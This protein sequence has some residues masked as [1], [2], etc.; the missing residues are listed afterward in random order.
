MLFRSVSQ[1]RYLVNGIVDNSERLEGKVAAEFVNVE[2]AQDI[3]GT[4]TFTNDV[5]I[6]GNLTIHGTETVVNSETVTTKDN[7]IVINYGEV[8]AGVTA[9]KA[10]IKVDRGTEPDYEFVFIEADDS[11]KIGKEGELQK[12]A[13]REDIPIDTGLAAWD[14]STS[15]FVTSR[16]VDVDSVS[17]GNGVLTW[18]TDQLL[19]NS[20][21]GCYVA[22]KLYRDWET[23]RKSV[24]RER[25]SSPV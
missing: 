14:A 16:D 23:D 6:Q 17:L 25:V 19:V 7:Q 5:V 10:G 24:V 22:R 13:T 11:F 15:K 2:D 21:I 8:G 4:K 18:D 1:S 9:G 20:Y 12:V 3:G